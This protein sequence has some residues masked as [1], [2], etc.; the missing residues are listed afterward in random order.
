MHPRQMRE[1]SRP[2][3]PSLVYSMLVVLHPALLF[4]ERD[5]RAA[6]L[7]CGFYRSG[8]GEAG[9]IGGCST[10]RWRLCARNRRYESV[11]PPPVPGHRQPCRRGHRGVRAGHVVCGQVGSGLSPGGRWIR[12]FGSARDRTSFAMSRRQLGAALRTSCVG[13]ALRTS[14]VQTGA[15]GVAAV[16]LDLFCSANHSTEPGAGRD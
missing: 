12:T 8:V 11:S 3:R 13:A 14:C 15:A 6:V 7:R 5:R 9:R 4:R 2:V 10:L 1:T 16:Q